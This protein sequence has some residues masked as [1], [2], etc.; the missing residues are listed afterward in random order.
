MYLAYAPNLETWLR[1]CQDNC[2]SKNCQNCCV[3][4][5][6]DAGCCNFQ[7]YFLWKHY[8]K[9]VAYQYTATAVEFID[10]FF[11]RNIKKIFKRYW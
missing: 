1:A 7:R 4:D 6:G 2:C 9:F 10:V 8:V 11:L 5:I 3:E